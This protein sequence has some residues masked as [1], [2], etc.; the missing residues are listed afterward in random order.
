MYNKVIEC[1]KEYGYYFYEYD[2]VSFKG[3]GFSISKVIGIESN[4]RDNYYLEFDA[5]GDIVVRDIDGEFVH[6]IE[7]REHYKMIF[8]LG[9]VLERIL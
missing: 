6:V 4:V 1:L 7:K 8:E 2:K 5:A 3:K 9:R